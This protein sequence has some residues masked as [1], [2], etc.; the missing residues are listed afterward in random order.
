MRGGLRGKVEVINDVI[1]IFSY[2]Y[3]HH[4]HES[5]LLSD[6]FRGYGV[7]QITGESGSA[8]PGRPWYSGPSLRTLRYYGQ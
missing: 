4:F 3:L 7:S 5:R 6:V 1:Y 2:A 8:C